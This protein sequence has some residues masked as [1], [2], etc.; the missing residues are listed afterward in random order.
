MDRFIAR[1]NIAY[2]EDLLVRETDPEKR[3][4]VQGLLLSEREKLEIAQR[5]ADT[6]R[7]PVAP[8]S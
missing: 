5:Q 1:T 3:R 4:I 6:N 7:K 2:F 8:K